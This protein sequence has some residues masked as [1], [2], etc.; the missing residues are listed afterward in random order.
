VALI[1]GKALQGVLA[2]DA[3]AGYLVMRRLASLITRQLT[4]TGAQ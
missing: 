4:P 3:V 2:G 1:D